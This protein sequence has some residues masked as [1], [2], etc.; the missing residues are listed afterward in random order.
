MGGPGSPHLPL[1]SALLMSPRADSD[2]SVSTPSAR[3]LGMLNMDHERGW[4]LAA[5]NDHPF[6]LPATPSHARDTALTVNLP[7]TPQQYMRVMIP[8]SQGCCMY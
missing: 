5:L 6:V 3:T 7:E 8:N 2:L 4:V 1:A